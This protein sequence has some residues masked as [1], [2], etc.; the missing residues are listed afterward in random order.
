[1]RVITLS[2]EAGILSQVKMLY[3]RLQGN[4]FRKFW[5]G[6]LNILDKHYLVFNKA[7]KTL[8]Q[9]FYLTYTGLQTNF[10][11]LR[12]ETVLNNH[13]NRT[14]VNV[15]RSKIKMLFLYL[16]LLSSIVVSC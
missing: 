5:Q 16:V 1:M 8:A 3:P 6:S 15:N 14:R 13:L 12:P 4:V 7:I 10:F 9:K 2:V 11:H